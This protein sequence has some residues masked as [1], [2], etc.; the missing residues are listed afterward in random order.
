MPGLLLTLL[1]AGIV[2]IVIGLGGYGIYQALKPARNKSLAFNSPVLQPTPQPTP[3][4]TPT[5]PPVPATPVTIMAERGIV[6]EA[7][8]GTRVIVFNGTRQEMERATGKLSQLDFDRYAIDLKLLS[9]DYAPRPPDARERSLSDLLGAIQEGHEPRLVAELNQRLSS[10]IFALGFA[11]VGLAAIL[12]GEFNRRGQGRRILGAIVAVTLLQ[13]AGLGIGNLAA[14]NNVFVPLQY[15]IVLV[16]VIAGLWVL[17]RWPAGRVRPP[18][19]AG[20]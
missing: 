10:P 8:A 12:S 18:A 17:L 6:V 4:S 20:R 16:P 9:N 14:N 11:M 13:S 3:Q 19:E 5:R 1:V 15:G 2:L 7:G